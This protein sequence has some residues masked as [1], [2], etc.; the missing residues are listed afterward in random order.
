MPE[1]VGVEGG[2]EPPPRLP[3]AAIACGGDAGILLAHQP[4]PPIGRSLFLD[5]LRRPVGRAVVHH[6]D[7][8]R[9]V[10]LG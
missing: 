9:P 5:D 10:C 3:H 4:D 1:I 7:L 8:D 2:D 6:D